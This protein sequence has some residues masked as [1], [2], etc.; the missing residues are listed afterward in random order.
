MILR[1]RLVQFFL[2]F[3]SFLLI[4]FMFFVYLFYKLFFLSK[5]KL[6]Y[7]LEGC[8]CRLN[9]FLNAV[10][11][12]L[13]YCGNLKSLIFS[14]FFCF[15]DGSFFNIPQGISF[16]N[17]LLA[18]LLVLRAFVSFIFIICS[19]FAKLLVFFAKYFYLRCKRS[20]FFWNLVS[21]CG[22]LLF[23]PLRFIFSW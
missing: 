9:M 12:F 2:R 16:F 20:V 4:Y 8:Y 23:L 3:L 17:V 22:L 13:D 11:F 5:I 15:L 1:W 6:F 7:F 19:L 21:K 14:Y 18:L 10:V